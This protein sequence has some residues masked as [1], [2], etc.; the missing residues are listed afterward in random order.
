M[1]PRGS[2]NSQVE[3]LRETAETETSK[4]QKSAT[5]HCWTEM[6]VAA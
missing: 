1:V 3:L 2:P 6:E 4:L 5:S